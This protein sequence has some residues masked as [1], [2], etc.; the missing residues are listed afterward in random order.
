MSSTSEYQT[1]LLAKAKEFL[2][3]NANYFVYKF[4]KTSVS[5]DSSSA[6]IVLGSDNLVVKIPQEHIG[7]SFVLEDTNLRIELVN[8]FLPVK[9]VQINPTYDAS[10]DFD[11]IREVLETWVG[12]AMNFKR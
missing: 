2:V 6:K 8:S 3:Y 10:V 1:E 11:N 7:V 4:G 5:L 9:V 12:K